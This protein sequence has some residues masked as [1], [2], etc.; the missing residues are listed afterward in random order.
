M[1]VELKASDSS[2]NGAI[3]IGIFLDHLCQLEI[4]VFDSSSSRCHVNTL[5]HQMSIELFEEGHAQGN[6]ARAVADV[7]T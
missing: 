7:L 1:S 6:V 2:S 4:Q 5:T 3:K